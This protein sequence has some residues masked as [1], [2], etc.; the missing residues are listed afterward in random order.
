[1]SIDTSPTDT[2]FRAFRSAYDHFNRVLFGGTLCPV[3]LNFSRHANSLGFFAPL[4]WERE[5]STTHEI[6]LNPSYLA[7]RDPRDVM[8]TLVHE[9]AHCWQQEHGT[10]GRRGYH[11]EEWARKMESIG[12]MPSSTGA[13]G[14]ARTGERMTHYIIEG[15]A[16]AR[17]FTAMPREY[18]LPWVCGESAS[19]KVKKPK[20]TSKLKFTCPTCGANA[21][22][23]PTLHLACGDCEIDMIAAD[24]ASDD[25]ACAA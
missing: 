8:S 5:A 21:W 9:M 13:P 15:G 23:R 22:G 20:A 16:F 18:L 24:A 6:S 11:N 10:P 1:M 19:A 17:A 2:Q 12:L 7:Q 3:I 14:G 25:R 4:R